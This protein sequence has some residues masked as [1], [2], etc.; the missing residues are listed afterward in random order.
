MV[1]RVIQALFEQ[2]TMIFLRPVFNPACL[3][4]GLCGR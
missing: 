4:V 1:C 3:A 2:T